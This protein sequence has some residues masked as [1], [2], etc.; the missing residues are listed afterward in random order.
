MTSGS[1][2]CAMAALVVGAVA[3]GWFARP[4]DP[5]ASVAPPDAAPAATVLVLVMGAS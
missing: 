5:P 1:Y 2:R 3:L 4:V